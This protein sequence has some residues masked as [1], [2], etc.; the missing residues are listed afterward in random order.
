VSLSLQTPELGTSALLRQLIANSAD[1]KVPLGALVGTMGARAYGLFLIIGCIPCIVPGLAAISG[2]LVMWA[3]AQMLLGYTQPWL[4]RRLSERTL[5]RAQ[6]VRGL[7]LVAPCLTWLERLCRPCWPQVWRL[8]GW[9]FCGFLLVI[10]GLALALPIPLTNY[11]L[12]APIVLIALALVERDGCMLVLGWLASILALAVVA[13]A[14]TALLR[15]IWQ[16]LQ[17]F[18]WI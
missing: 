13:V 5:E 1:A 9:I 10:L 7:D 18:A 12:A 17:S 15:E 14:Y 4:P 8:G 16:W 3:G 11:V 2:P 6:L